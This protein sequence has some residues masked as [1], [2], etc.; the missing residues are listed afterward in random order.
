MPVVKA[1]NMF[2]DDSM[3]IGWTIFEI[4]MLFGFITLIL[5]AMVIICCRYCL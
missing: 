2:L 1:E 5:V 4:F 3:Q